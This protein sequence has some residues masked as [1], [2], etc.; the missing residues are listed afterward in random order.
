MA[1]ALSDN[2]LRGTK[3]EIEANASLDQGKKDE[4]IRVSLEACAPEYFS[5]PAASRVKLDRRNLG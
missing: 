4:V 5:R 1:V 2:G 3:A